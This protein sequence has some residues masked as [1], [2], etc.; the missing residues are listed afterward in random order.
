M[1][2][3][4]LLFV[5]ITCSPATEQHWEDTGCIFTAS[6][7]YFYE[8]VRSPWAFFF[9]TEQFHLSVSPHMQRFQ[10]CDQLSALYYTPGAIYP[11]LSC[12]S[13]VLGRPHCP[14][15]VTPQGWVNTREWSPLEEL[16]AVSGAHPRCCWP[17]LPQ[18]CIACSCSTWCLPFLQNS[19]PSG[20]P[21]LRPAA[22]VIQHPVPDTAVPCP[23]CHQ[24]AAPAR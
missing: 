9:Q 21:R 8:L 4:V 6:H 2:F 15:C 18:G 13:R 17:P 23:A 3:S 16:A 14:R 7:Q 5:S 24:Q 22:R 12:S 19:F 10:S 1:E 11:C 20:W